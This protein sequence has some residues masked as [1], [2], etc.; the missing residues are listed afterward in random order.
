[1]RAGSVGMDDD[2][3]AEILIR[4]EIDELRAL[5]QGLSEAQRQVLELRF[6]AQLSLAET[7]QVMD[8]SVDAVKSLQYAAVRALREMIAPDGEPTSREKGLAPR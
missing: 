6:A 4:L 5:M 7:A 3:E 2:P 1:V 8:R